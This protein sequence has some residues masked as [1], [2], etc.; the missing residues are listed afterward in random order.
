MP[1]CAAVGC[2]NR[3]N[4]RPDLLWKYLPTKEKDSSLKEL[5]LSKI[6]RKHGS[7]L[8]HD[9]NIVLCSEHFANEC[10]ERDYKKEFQCEDKK[11][12]Y[13]IKEGAVPTIFAHTNN[14]RTRKSSEIRSKRAEKRKL[15][16]E[17]CPSVSAP[18][19]TPLIVE[20]VYNE[21]CFSGL[22]TT[23]SEET[24]H[25]T[26]HESTAANSN[27]IRET[28][29]NTDV[30]FSPYSDVS[31]SVSPT[32]YISNSATAPYFECP[33]TTEG[34]SENPVDDSDLSDDST[35]SND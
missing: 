23:N 8:P 33:K 19:S 3:S 32:E 35:S 29:V 2:Q 34:G 5:W 26:E 31:F 7:L 25:S 10:I 24:A 12:F 27:T 11:E 21:L 13:K 22:P 18:S 9:R 4:D 17:V 15:F 20:N 6:K 30:S 14:P 16:D 28:S 1:T